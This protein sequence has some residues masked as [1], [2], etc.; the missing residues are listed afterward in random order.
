MMGEVMRLSQ[1]E[2]ESTPPGIEKRRRGRHAKKKTE[3][4]KDGMAGG[5]A[6]TP[7]QTGKWVTATDPVAFFSPA[8]QNLGR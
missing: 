3:H 8:C 5:G 2:G 1:L 7:S 6:M 4:R